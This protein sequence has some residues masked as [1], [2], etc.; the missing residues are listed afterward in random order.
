MRSHVSRSLWRASEL[1]RTVAR[2]RL[3]R[4]A[5]WLALAWILLVQVVFY[6]NMLDQFGDELVDRIEGIFGGLGS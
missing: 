6:R 3:R 5:P 4:L 1:I 2:S